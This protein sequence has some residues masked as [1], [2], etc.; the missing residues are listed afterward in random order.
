[1]NK[2]TNGAINVESLPGISGIIHLD[3]VGSTQDAAREI[4]IDSDTENRLVIAECQEAGRGRMG[5]D[6]SSGRGGVYV[7]LVLKPKVQC[8]FL[9]GLSVFVAEVLG[10]TL[11]SLYSIK[12][13]VKKPNDVY[14]FH[15]RKKKWRKIAG[16]LTTLATINK[17]ANW[18]LIGIGVNIN[19]ELPAEIKDLAVSVRQIKGKPQSREKF[20]E[21][22]FE[23]F[24]EKY[25]HWQTGS[26]VRSG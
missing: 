26:E 13:R 14:A 21:K 19:N 7:T 6:W 24:W 18:V 20:L 8:R 2:I 4:S 15:P 9:Q 17:D 25:S 23:L 22:F 10:E 1:M 11:S 16:V 3:S 5:R 12:C